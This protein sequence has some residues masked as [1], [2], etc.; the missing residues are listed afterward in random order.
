[1]QDLKIEYVNPK[2]LKPYERNARRHAEYDVE[3]IKASIKAFG[4][5]DPIGVWGKKKLIVEGHGRTQA[6]IELGLDRVPII[7]LDDMTDEQRRA[8][9][10]AHNKTAELSSW[11]FETLNAELLDI[12]NI[13]MTDFGFDIPD[14]NG[15]DD[16]GYYGDEQ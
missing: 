8:Y 4:F 3:A 1:M 9:A 15:E 16:D 14:I 7:R 11:N 13:D 10:L 5:R 12:E 2:D 6:A